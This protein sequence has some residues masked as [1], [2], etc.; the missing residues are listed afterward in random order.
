MTRR[1]R[2]FV[3]LGALGLLAAVPA[4]FASAGLGGHGCHRDGPP[5]AE[6]V[7]AHM[8]RAAGWVLDEVDA[9]DDQVAAIDAILD[10]AAPGLIALH[11]EGHQLHL[12]LRDELSAAT[13]DPAAV[14][15][16]RQ[17]GLA[18]ADRASAQ[19][20]GWVV[21][22]ANVLDAEQRAT[23]ADIEP[24]RHGPPHEGGPRR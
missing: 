2:I 22:A 9:S 23:L 13:V 7:R 20:L 24:P 15:D 1:S 16:I 12:D 19:V 3:A 5:D 18:L 8:G 6:E 17:D 4:A 14:E 21:S 11:E 10:E